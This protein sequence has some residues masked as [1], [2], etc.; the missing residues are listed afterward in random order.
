MP[1]YR[2]LSKYPLVE[3]DLG[4]GCGDWVGYFTDGF[5][6]GPTLFY[7]A[8]VQWWYTY[9]YVVYQLCMLRWYGFVMC[10][11]SW[12][13]R[14]HGSWLLVPPFGSHQGHFW[15]SFFSRFSS[16]FRS[17]SSLFGPFS[18]FLHWFW[19]FLDPKWSHIFGTLGTR[20]FM[21]STNSGKRIADPDDPDQGLHM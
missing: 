2:N 6:S 15:V 13:Y 12:V 7:Y 9:H 16:W 20:I 19:S 21:K 17:K 3:C 4:L 8:I 1:T 10:Y 5:F 11:R 14:C 18:S